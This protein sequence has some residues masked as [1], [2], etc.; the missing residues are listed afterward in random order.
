MNNHQSRLKRMNDSLIVAISHRSDIE[1]WHIGNIP[2][3]IFLL[4]SQFAVAGLYD[5]MCVLSCEYLMMVLFLCE[6]A[7]AV[8]T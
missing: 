8:P 1:E 2:D 7:C 6:S 3:D 4:I 5:L